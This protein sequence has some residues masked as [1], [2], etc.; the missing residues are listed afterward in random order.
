VA[1]AVRQRIVNRVTTPL[2]VL[3]K[4]RFFFYRTSDSKKNIDLVLFLSTVSKVSAHVRGR[5]CRTRDRAGSGQCGI[6][7]MSG[8]CGR[9]PKKPTVMPQRGLS[10]EVLPGP[11][12]GS[13]SEA[14]GEVTECEGKPAGNT[15]GRVCSA[16][17]MD[18]P[19]LWTHG[20]ARA[21]HFASNTGDIS[22]PRRGPRVRRLVAT[23][24]LRAGG[25]AHRQL[26]SASPYQNVIR[27]S[28]CLQPDR[29]RA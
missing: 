15:Y 24:A 19:G 22:A 20:A 6:A 25:P 28:A 23:E 12:R 18:S 3:T 29:W 21:Q 4:P 8:L 26:V 14:F 5:E 2:S 13:C 17:C 1:A 11:L 9:G 7:R 16:H 10:R 27:C